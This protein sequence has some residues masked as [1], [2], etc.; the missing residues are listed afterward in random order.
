MTPESL[1]YQCP[2]CGGP[3]HYDAQTGQP[4]CEYCGSAFTVEQVEAFYAQQQAKADAEAA[5]AAKDVA[6]SCSKAAPSAGPAAA[7]GTAG[8]AAAPTTAAPGTAAAASMSQDSSVAAEHSTGQDGVQ[9]YLNSKKPLSEDGPGATCVVCSSCGANLIVSQNTA[10]SQCPY[11]GNN[12]VVPGTLG[13]TLMPDLVI[14][15]ATTKQQAIDALANHYKGKFLLP[16]AFKSANHIQEIQGVYV[17][18]WL[19]DAQAEGSANYHCENH[20]YWS[21]SEYDY[22]ETTTFEC[23]RAGSTEFSGIP[24]DGSKRMPNDMMDSIEPYDYSQFRPFSMAYLPGFL[25]DRYDEGVTACAPR[26]E[27]R[28]MSSLEVDL[29]QTVVGYDTVVPSGINGTVNYGRISYAL[30]PVW[31]LHTTWNGKDYL[32]AM[33]GQ[34]GKMVGDLPCD[35]KKMLLTGLGIFLGVAAV[36]ILASLFLF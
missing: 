36:S 13:D 7:P 4:S 35:Y 26:A 33:N 1:T 5:T 27:Q 20:R 15:F 24:A 29:R 14:P 2:A 18:F 9:A 17:P 23:F 31:M 30:M 8:T 25:T 21:D 19:F 34:T 6:G 28:A 22:V 16:K 11:C 3:L 32:F 10:V 12:T